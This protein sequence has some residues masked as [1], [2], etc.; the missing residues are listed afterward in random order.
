MTELCLKLRLAPFVNM[1]VELW[2]KLLQPQQTDNL[3]SHRRL[4]QISGR[5]TER[6]R[7]MRIIIE[8]EVREHRL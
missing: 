3:A 1:V 5:F 4:P 7:G 6:D 2:A 8:Q